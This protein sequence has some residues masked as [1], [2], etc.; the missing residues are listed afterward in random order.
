[1]LNMRLSLILVSAIVQVIEGRECKDKLFPPKPYG[2]QFELRH[3]RSTSVL[4]YSCQEGLTLWGKAEFYCNDGI[5]NNGEAIEA[6]SCA[7]AANKALKLEVSTSDRG[8]MMNAYKI[9]DAVYRRLHDGK[10]SAI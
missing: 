3:Y 7:V 1:M 10:F 5:W 2:G 4:S 8:A 9:V 6:P